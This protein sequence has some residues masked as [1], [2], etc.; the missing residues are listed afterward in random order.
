MWQ[1]SVE[2]IKPHVVKITTPGGSG[3]GFQIS[4]S[5]TAKLCAVATVA[6]VINHAHY[7]EDPVRLFHQ[8][9]QATILLH[10]DQRVI[11]VDIEHDTA[12]I[13]FN[14]T[15]IPFPIKTLSMTTEG[16]YIKI[17]NELGWIGYP[18][19]SPTNLCLFSGRASCYLEKEF[20]YLVDGVAINGVSGGPAFLPLTKESIMIVGVV[21]AYVPNRATGDTLPGLC[22]IQDV[23]Q[24]QDL[25]K[26]FK[27][28]DEAKKKE[29]PPI[30]PPDSQSGDQR[31]NEQK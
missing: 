4:T 16:K 5:E 27:T 13:I 24:F 29:T 30:P 10:H 20:A 12:A 8:E 28:L 25:A 6:H 7:W 23:I 31:P 26:R 14:K 2:I 9:S 21:S 18:A 17:G 1:S 19:V 3:T 11:L 22:V 15:L